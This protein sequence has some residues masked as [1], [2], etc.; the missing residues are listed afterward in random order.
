MVLPEDSSDYCLCGSLHVTYGTAI[1]GY[2][3]LGAGT[4]ISLIPHDSYDTGIDPFLSALFIIM[5]ILTAA[6]V[7]WKRVILLVTVVILLIVQTLFIVLIFVTG[8]IFR[9]ASNV[10]STAGEDD[11]VVLVFTLV[12]ITIVNMWYLKTIFKCI[13]WLR[14]TDTVTDSSFNSRPLM[15]YQMDTVCIVQ[16]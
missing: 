12:L 11:L 10:H 7:H 1:I 5:G 16:K 6:G 2:F 15:Y 13:K 8:T 4:L 3:Y 14:R 9:L